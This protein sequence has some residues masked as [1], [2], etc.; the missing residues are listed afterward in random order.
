MSLS[1]TLRAILMVILV[2]ATACSRES[3][4]PPSTTRQ[5]QITSELHGE[6][7]GCFAGKRIFYHGGIEILVFS[8]DRSQEIVRQLNSFPARPPETPKEIEELIRRRDDLIQMLKRQ[9]GESKKSKTDHQ[10]I[11]RVVGLEPGREY[12]VIGIVPP[13][14]DSEEYFLQARTGKLPPGS[15]R[16]DLW[17]GGLPKQ[18]C[19]P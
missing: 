19:H 15:T 16:M 7:A 14:E 12:L 8:V 11:Y 5:A 1:W 3:N 10:G 18:N 4:Q 13:A 17:E 9:A 2:G 6:A